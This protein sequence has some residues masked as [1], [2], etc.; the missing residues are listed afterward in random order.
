ML[1]RNRGGGRRRPRDQKICQSYRPL[2]EQLETRVVPSL[3]F[4]A[5]FGG[6]GGTLTLNGSAQ[7]NGQ[8]L[9]LTQGSTGQAGSAFSTAPQDI[10]SFHSTFT[11]QLTN[12]EADGFTF[13]I[14]AG[15]S[16]ALGPP[17]GGLGYGPDHTGGAGGIVNSVAVKFDLFDNQG[18]GN[19]STGLFADGAA[20]TNVGS[21]NLGAGGIDLH[22][23]HVFRVGTTYD[24]T[25]LKVLILDANTGASN[26]QNYTVD[27][28][29]KVGGST[30]FVGFTGATGALTATQGI[31]NWTY[32][33][34][35]ATPPLAPVATAVGG[36]GHVVLNW[37]PVAGADS[38]NIYRS[39]TAGG[40]GATPL[41]TGVNGTAFTDT[42]VVPG[43][44][45]F[46]EV[47]GVGIGGEGSRS[48][49]VSATPTAGLDFS[50]G[51]AGAGSVLTTNGSAKFTSDPALEL[52]D[53]NT[54]EA[55][56]AFA[57]VKQDITTF[58]TSFSFRLTAAVADGFTFCIQGDAATAVGPAGGG[59]GYGPDHTGGTG[60][61]TNSV[62]VKFDLFDN[63]GEGTDS[64]GLFTDG[65]APT[66]VGSVNLSATGID[67]HSEH[68]FNVAMNYNGTT[69]KVVI[70][71]T[72]SG[73]SNTQNYT[74]NIPTTVGA[75]S[76][77]VGFT[78]ATGGLAAKQDILN[79]TFG[80]VGTATVV[81]S[82]PNPSIAGQTVTFT[83]T[84][85][86]TGFTAV[87]PTGSVD[88]KEGGTDLTPGGV[89]L[90]GAD[91]A[92][93]TTSTLAVG[94]HTITGIYSGDGNFQA[95]TG[96]DSATPQVVNK[97]STTTAVSSTANP[98]VSGQT[99]TFTAS[100]A[101]VA[102]GT[103]TPTGTVD[104]KEGATDLTPGGVIVN[105]AGLATFAIS[106]L[107][108]GSH[109]IT[110]T[111]GGSASFLTS[112]GDDS[113]SPQV[114]N[115]ASTTTTADSA[116]NPAVTDQSYTFT[117]TVVPV[118]PGSG[119]PTGMVTFK[120]SDLTVMAPLN[121]SGLATFVDQ[122]FAGDFGPV[123]AIYAGDMNFLGSMGKTASDQVVNLASTKTTVTSTPNPSTSGTTVTFTATVAVVPPGGGTP[124]G[125][126]NFTEGATT[127]ASSVTL[128]AGVA[129]FTT[130][131]LAAGSHTITAAY[132]GEAFF[133]MA[134]TGDDSAAPQVVT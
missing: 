132:N 38:Y 124:G 98:S 111:Y 31:V 73:V 109:T 95:S 58:N 108:V 12:A 112:T 90:N 131:S 29:T 103:G 43:T 78:G 74:V 118:A 87:T 10:T 46:Y 21:V 27:I 86:S 48:A 134:S 83:A 93:F 71:D 80:K 106:S 62:A 66:N 41:Q 127:L 104:F 128:G 40:E 15:A 122:S 14:Q 64:T 81:K 9:Q 67:L 55:A 13:C 120:L 79:W 115:K 92:T 59:L 105:G 56:S 54:G 28:P 35:A 50:G 25:T 53:G 6:A 121:G 18:E 60:G 133:Y 63:Q 22:S 23:G 4:A 1:R 44:T 101:A 20:P 126:V 8:V 36:P 119:T 39:T 61:I 52:T 16:S 57:N 76:A 91:Q 75:S 82:S 69:L 72:N 114:V 113:A 89:T 99:V 37:M 100:V 2:L 45:Y 17:G 24:G 32:T 77:F 94:T 70:L 42:N 96:D 5:G 97:A 49:E 47:T 30:A 110:A 107:A 3:D 123:T 84:V 26:T 51:F 85:S 130:S 65:A 34:G 19:D 116:P 88:F 11:F 102:P 125:T 117:A 7:V 68:V 33:E 129:T